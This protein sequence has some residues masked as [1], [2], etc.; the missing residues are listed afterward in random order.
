MTGKRATIEKIALTAEE[1]I[2]EGLAELGL[3]KD[4]VEIEILDE[5]KQGLFGLGSRQ[6]R[7]RLTI[8]KNYGLEEQVFAEPAEQTPPTVEPITD[9]PAPELYQETDEI[10]DVDYAL[11]VAHKTVVEL[12]DKMRIDAEVTASFG[13]S[14]SYDR[15]PIHV[16]IH[17]DDL[18]IL[19]GRKAET[20]NALQYI[21]SLIVG[22]ELGHSASVIVDVE[23]YRNRREKQLRQLAHRIAEQVMQTGRSQALEPMPPNERRL[24][25]IE[26]R[27]DPYVYT[28]SVGDGDR[29][30]VVVF[31]KE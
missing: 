13:E 12:L 16:D 28:E 21:T 9:E 25:H 30:K 8:K 22:K 19:I 10:A 20:L 4:A 6:A 3:A 27:N 14:D 1:A 23:G 7:V 2:E 29:R 5:G 18:S 15:K 31:P 24:I 17:G 26:L 11:N